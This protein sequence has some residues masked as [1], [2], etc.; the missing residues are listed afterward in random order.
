MHADSKN[1]DLSSNTS[2]MRQREKQ[3][4]FNTF[5]ELVNYKG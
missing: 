5:I 3:F 1:I 4:I 2:S